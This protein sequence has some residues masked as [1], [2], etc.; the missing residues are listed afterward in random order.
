MDSNH[1]RDIDGMGVPEIKYGDSVCFVQHI[2]SGLWVTYKAQEAK[3]SRLGP[4]KRKVSGQ[5]GCP[6]LFYTVGSNWSES[7]GCDVCS[8]TILKSFS[9]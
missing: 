3:T 5:K 4:L 7:D 9:V 1:K 2:A 6:E 8:V